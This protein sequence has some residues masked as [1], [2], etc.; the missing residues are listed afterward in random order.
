MVTSDTV[1]I[2]AA[3]NSGA[4]LYVPDG[5]FYIPN[6]TT[7]TRSTPLKMQ[8]TGTIKGLNKADIF[9]KC[10]SDV[11]V[12]GVGFEQFAFVFKNEKT[13]SGTVDKFYLSN[14]TIKDCGG[15]ISL[16]RPVNTFTVTDCDFNTLTANKP[17]RVGYNTYE[18]QNNW[19]NF[20]ITGNTFRNISTVSGS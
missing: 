17:L 12:T 6:W 5:T 15:G 2:T 19:K 1:A 20:S 11:S 13:D 4:S 8:G 14:V 10:L 7:I 3:I 9:V 18:F 16:E